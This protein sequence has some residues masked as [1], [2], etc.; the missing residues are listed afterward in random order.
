MFNIIMPVLF[1]VQP[2]VEP[3]TIDNWPDLIWP[4]L[5]F[6]S[7]RDQSKFKEILG[8]GVGEIR[9]TIRF[10][11]TIVHKKPD[12]FNHILKAGNVTGAT[13]SHPECHWCKHFTLGMPLVQPLHTG[14]ATG[15]TTSHWECHWCNHFTLGMPLVQPLHT[16]NATGATTSHWECHWCNHFTLGM[17]LVQPLHTGNA[18]GATTLHNY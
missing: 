16:G 18:T 6:L 5:L 2:R 11:L 14:N 17:P 1:L 13:T 4:D 12:R 15:A 9:F 7:S 8:V 10:G 3:E